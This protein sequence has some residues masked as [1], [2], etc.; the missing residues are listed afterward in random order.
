MHEPIPDEESIFPETDIRYSTFGSRL[1]ASLIDGLIMIAA[2]LPLTYYNIGTFKMPLLYVLIALFTV[3]YKP[4]LEYRYGAT[5][6]KMLVGLKV[7]GSD[8][9][10]ITLQE[11]MRRVSFYLVPS[12][13][14][15]VLTL[16][17]Y[18]SATFKSISDY[19]EFNRYIVSENPSLIWINVIVMILVA[20]DT[21]T[22]FAQQPNRALH[23]IYAGTYVIEKK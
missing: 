2:T 7:V 10:K 9:G 20:A 5:W 1:G 3:L 8:F 22:F 19:K 6:G 12:I 18:F 14:Q 21:I 23:D 13:L 15:H 4:F 16:G 17:V 11:E